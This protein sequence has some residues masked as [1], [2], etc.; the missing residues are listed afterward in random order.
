MRCNKWVR[1][2][3][4]LGGG[5]GQRSKQWDRHEINITDQLSGTTELLYYT[6]YYIFIVFINNYL[7]TDLNA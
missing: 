1:L 4:Q 3:G 2:T 6:V 7:M 5:D